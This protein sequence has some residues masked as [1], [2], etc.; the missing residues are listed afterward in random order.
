MVVVLA[1]ACSSL[2]H[3]ARTCGASSS[4]GAWPCPEPCRDPCPS[5]IL[6][7]WVA[8]G[9]GRHSESGAARGAGAVGPGLEIPPPQD[10]GWR[11][12]RARGS[13]IARHVGPGGGSRRL[14]EDPATA[15]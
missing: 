11:R 2:S 4:V 13:E 9:A 5:G 3:C 6:P 14:G 1:M 10:L 7:R 8:P 12:A 15:L